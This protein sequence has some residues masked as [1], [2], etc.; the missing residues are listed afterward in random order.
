MRTS[1]TFTGSRATSPA[2]SGRSNLMT[3]TKPTP[4]VQVRDC[5]RGGNQLAEEFLDNF[6]RHLLK[7]A[8]NRAA[9][10]V[11]WG[12]GTFTLTVATTEKENSPEAG[13]R[14]FGVDVTLTPKE[15]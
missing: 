8:L 11:P 12:G 6:R 13:S 5:L 10:V 4:Q 15:E 3:E 2:T 7:T 9:K 1:G 14:E